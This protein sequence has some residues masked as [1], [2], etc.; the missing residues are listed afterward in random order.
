MR[1]NHKHFPGL[2]HDTLIVNFCTCFSDVIL[3][4]NQWAHSCEM[5]MYYIVSQAILTNIMLWFSVS[6]K[7]LLIALPVTGFVVLL[8]LG[9]TIYCCCCRKK[10]RFR[11]YVISFDANC[12][13]SFCKYTVCW[14][15]TPDLKRCFVTLYL[16]DS[17]KK[18]LNGVVNERK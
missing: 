4:R 11:G 12:Y 7:I 5:S 10:K 9:C 18:K 14:H 15:S 16:I 6:G 1:L 17:I 3:Q 8:A 2:G 13:I